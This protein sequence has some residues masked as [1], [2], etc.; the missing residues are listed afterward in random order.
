MEA[1]KEKRCSGSLAFVRNDN[2]QLNRTFFSTVRNNH[3][4]LF[5]VRFSVVVIFNTKSTYQYNME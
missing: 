2:D 3:Q 4:P 5:G 1:G